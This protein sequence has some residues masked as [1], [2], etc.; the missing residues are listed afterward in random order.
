MMTIRLG[1]EQP[2]RWLTL[3]LAIGTADLSG[4]SIVGFA[5][6]SDA[7]VTTTSRVCLRRGVE[8]GLR[9]VFFAKTVVSFPKTALHL[10]VLDLGA[11]PELASPAPWREL[12]M[13]FEIASAEICLRDFRFFAI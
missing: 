3:N 5:C 13:F 2:G 7:A 9:D 8:G 11:N 6:K 1:V 4:C 12:V 10:D